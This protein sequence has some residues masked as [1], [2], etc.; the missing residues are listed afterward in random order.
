MTDEK[1]RTA[2]GVPRATIS[3]LGSMVGVIVV[4]LRRTYG[5]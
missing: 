5:S 4:A 3:P 2:G 1:S